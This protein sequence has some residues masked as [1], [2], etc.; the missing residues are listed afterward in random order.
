MY[1]WGKE[2]QESRVAFPICLLFRLLDSPT[3]FPVPGAGV[4]SFA[5]PSFCENRGL[6]AARSS[7]IAIL[8]RCGDSRDMEFIFFGRISVQICS[9]CP[10]V[11]GHCRARAATRLAFI[12]PRRIV[13]GGV[14]IA[15]LGIAGELVRG[16]N[17]EFHPYRRDIFG[18]MVRRFL[19]HFVLFSQWVFL[20]LMFFGGICGRWHRY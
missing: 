13:I 3:C 5:R 19:T 15:K 4:D 1:L 16:A 2:V 10:P 14:K 18:L 6:V 7:A 17:I 11:V 9:R 20:L 12:Y 8:R